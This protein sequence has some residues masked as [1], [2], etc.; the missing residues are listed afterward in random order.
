ML[1]SLLV[2]ILIAA[3]IAVF[4]CFV[5]D[6]LCGLVPMPAQVPMLLKLAVVVIAL[7]AILARAAPALGLHGI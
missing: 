7:V 5:V 2:F 4:L 3:V 1:T 6:V